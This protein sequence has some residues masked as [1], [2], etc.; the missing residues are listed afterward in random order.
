VI[1]PGA[2]AGAGNRLVLGADDIQVHRRST[3]RR[4]RRARRDRAD[5]AGVS[6][7]GVLEVLDGGGWSAEEQRAI[8]RAAGERPSERLLVLSFDDDF[9]PVRWVLIGEPDRVGEA[10]GLARD[11]PDE[12]SAGT[13]APRLVGG[14]PPRGRNRRRQ[15]AVLI[16]ALAL[17]VALGVAI[18]VILVRAPDGVD[19]DDGEGS[20]SAQVYES[21]TPGIPDP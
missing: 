16:L 13:D 15:G 19:L 11:W 21:V 8:H 9:G 20:S 14:R 10:E 3:L 18:A 4:S 7:G 5:L 2:P 17:V 12:A 6:S 1:L